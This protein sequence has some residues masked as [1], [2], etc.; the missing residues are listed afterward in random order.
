MNSRMQQETASPVEPPSS[1]PS[2]GDYI[3]FEEVK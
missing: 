3:E 2:D 1:K